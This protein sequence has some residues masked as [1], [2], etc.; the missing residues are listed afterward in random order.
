MKPRGRRLVAPSWPEPRKLFLSR[1]AICNVREPLSSPAGLYG[2]AAASSSRL[3]LRRTP[4]ARPHR[5]HCRPLPH[6]PVG[7]ACPPGT[8]SRKPIQAP[9]RNLGPSRLI[10]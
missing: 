1:T 10:S 8:T 9:A 3:P 2:P 4:S 6:T 7:V 5:A